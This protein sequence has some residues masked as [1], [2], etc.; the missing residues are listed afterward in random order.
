MR[1]YTHSVQPMYTDFYCRVSPAE[2]ARMIIGD[3]ILQLERDGIS[4]Q[5]L[6]DEKCGG[7]MVDKFRLEQAFYLLHGAF[8][9][10]VIILLLCRL[11]R[12]TKVLWLY[13][14]GSSRVG[15][16]DDDRIF[17]ADLPPL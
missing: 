7:W 8:L 10:L 5:K 17:K 14:T 9:H 6:I 4:R 11:C 12:K 2:M 13:N 1:E 15:G 16:H 3:T